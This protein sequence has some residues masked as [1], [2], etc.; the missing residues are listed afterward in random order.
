MKIY[1][2][3]IL[4]ESRYLNPT[5]VDIYSKNV[6]DEDNYVKV[7]LE[8]IGLKVGR[9]SWY[10]A[11]FN[12]S[13]T[14]YILFR[15]T[16]DYFDRYDEFS[17]WL[18]NVSKQTIL[19][20]SEAIIR[21]NIDKHYL[22]DLQKKEVPICESYF[23]ETTEKSSLQ[24]L[25]TKHQLNEFVLKPCVSG[26]GR[27]TYRINP[28]NTP[29][30]ETIFKKLIAKE[31]LILQP[32]Q[33][34]IV[35]KGE[36]SLILINGKFT[37]AVLKI[38]K[39]GDF[40]VQ[41]DFGGSVHNYTPTQPE[42]NFAEKAIK[43]CNELPIYARVDVFTDNNNNLALAELELIEPELWFRNNPKAADELAKGIQ[44]LINQKAV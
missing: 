16:W 28:Q 12:W 38:A 26:G 23:V 11:T 42:I 34:N 20:N 15:T 31:A 29:D 4:T 14:K 30:H 37:H 6:L 27:H 17:K 13:T 1:D 33:H 39:K 36:I 10:D 3:I 9:L 2:V 8:K 43:A 40:R 41:D 25:A 32:F 5:K 19:L 7:A 21:W 24:E 22:Q 44:K 18:N 35:K